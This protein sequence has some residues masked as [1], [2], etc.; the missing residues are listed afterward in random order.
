MDVLRSAFE[1]FGRR[2]PVG[3]AADGEIPKAEKKLRKIERETGKRP[4]GR[5]PDFLLLGAQKCGTGYLFTRLSR[6]PP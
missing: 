5:L 1:R 3:L 6:H 4:E 2:A